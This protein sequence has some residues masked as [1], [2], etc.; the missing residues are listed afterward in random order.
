MADNP[1]PP[2]DRVQTISR[3]KDGTPDQTDNFEIIGDRDTAVEA[4]AR[5]LGE[6][7]VSAAD[8]KRAA[9]QAAAA[10]GA[11][12]PSPEDQARI[13]EHEALLEQGRAMAE[14][15]VDAH[16]ATGEE[17]TT[18]RRSRKKAVETTAER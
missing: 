12:G 3:R 4:N 18:P 10:A 8:E 5:Q 15:E 6:M 1:T 16:L 14:T 11:T 7:L 9:G 17:E 13:D 2:V